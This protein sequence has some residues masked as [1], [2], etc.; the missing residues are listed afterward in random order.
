MTGRVNGDGSTNRLS[1]SSSKDASSSSSSGKAPSLPSYVAPSVAKQEE[2]NIFR[3]KILVCAIL[4]LAV[5]LVATL[6]YV[7]VDQQE[8]SNFENRFSGRA[9]ELLLLARQNAD[10]L[11]QALEGYSIAVSSQAAD[12]HAMH[13]TSWPFYIIPDFSIRTQN[14]VERTGSNSPYLGVFHI[15]EED[16][17]TEW[18]HF[19]EEVNP[20]WYQQS[21]ANEGISNETLKEWLNM[22]VPYLFEYD[23]N[24]EPVPI[25]RP[26]VTL[27]YM[28]QYPL[29]HYAVFST[30]TSNLDMLS[31]FAGVRDQFPITR[32]TGKPTIGLASY[33][34]NGT[35]PVPGG[36]IFQPIFN[37][38]DKKAKDRKIVAIADLVLEFRQ[39]FVNILSDDEKGILVVLKSACPKARD[40]SDIEVTDGEEAVITY[41]VDGPDAI[42]LGESDMHDTRYD[43]LEVAEVFFDLGVDPGEVPEATCAQALTL[44]IYPS[45]EFEDVFHT[46]NPIIYA[47]VVVVIFLFTTL[48]FGLYDFLVGRRQRKVMDR[49]FQQDKVVSNVFPTAIRERLYQDQGRRDGKRSAEQDDAMDR[50]DSGLAMSDS[51]P[52]ADLFTNVTVVFADI[53]GFTA[54]SSAREP[55]HVFVLLESIYGAFDRIA[56][57]HGVFKVETVGDCYVAA[58]GLPDP[59]QDH[60]VVACKFA[61]DCLKKMHEMTRKMEVS[62][63]PDTTELDLRIG[64]HSGQVTAGVLRGE[65][66]RF[67]LFGD[68]MNTAARMESGGERNRIQMS[69]VTADLMKKAGLSKWVIP[70]N[71]RIFVKGKGEMQTYWMKKGVSGKKVLKASGMKSDMSTVDETSMDDSDSTE[72]ASSDLD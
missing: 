36:Q 30:M 25:T 66:C 57:G 40:Y 34:V 56:H 43:A 15:V 55:Q 22:T 71:H 61:C 58:A 69:Q 63:G 10:Q 50:L 9:S 52:L 21:A 41:K 67:Q 20:F 8:Q 62:L 16:E 1:S 53:A 64:I 37:T 19:V 29:V 35:T 31:S 4:L 32:A 39:F 65:R 70:R 23:A 26:G 7:L 24:F 72:G 44:H 28:E 18:E 49:I 42:L 27:V 12:Y 47:S 60:A 68:T 3:A 54:W 6:A 38:P 11:V 5:T 13:N 33:S 14:L 45:R 48:V 59:I 2:V 17:R 46:A 51:A